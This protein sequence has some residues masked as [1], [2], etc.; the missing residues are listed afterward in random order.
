MFKIEFKP[1]TQNLKVEF[2]ELSQKLDLELNKEFIIRSAEGTY[3][4]EYVVTPDFEEQ[5]LATKNKLMAA[6]V[7]VEEIP[8]YVVSN[9]HNGQTFIIGKGDLTI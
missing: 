2:S 5:T 7:H 1:N 8:H 9:T 3:E 6:D 4:G